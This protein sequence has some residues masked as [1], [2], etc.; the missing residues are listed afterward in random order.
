MAEIEEFLKSQLPRL[1]EAKKALERMRKFIELGEEMGF[2][3][4][5]QRE[6][7]RELEARIRRWEAVTKRYLKE[8]K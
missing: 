2:D 1:E 6:R 5:K 4:S 7:M 3:V 8:G